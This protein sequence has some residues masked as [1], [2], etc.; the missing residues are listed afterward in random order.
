LQL[1]LGGVAGAVVVLK[2]F[3]RSIADRLHGM[4]HRIRV[5]LRPRT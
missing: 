4:S 2:L 1:L 5:L 3:W